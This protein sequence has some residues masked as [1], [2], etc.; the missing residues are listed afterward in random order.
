MPLVFSDGKY[1]VNL[2]INQETLD[3]LA[4]LILSELHAQGVL[5][6]NIP[7]GGNAPDIPLD[8]TKISIADIMPADPLNRFNG[9]RVGLTIKII[10]TFNQV[11]A[12]LNQQI[13]INLFNINVI[14][15]EVNVT[16]GGVEVLITR[17]PNGIGTGIGL[18]LRRVTS[19]ITTNLP[20]FLP[21]LLPLLGILPGPLPAGLASILNIVNTFI[22]VYVSLGIQSVIRLIGSVQIPI[23]QLT[24]IMAKF[25]ITFAKGS[26][27]IAPSQSIG[28]SGS[29]T[30]IVILG[31]FTRDGNSLPDNNLVTDLIPANMPGN[32]HTVAVQFDQDFCLQAVSIAYAK[33]ILD[34]PHNIAGIR[35]YVTSFTLNFKD[36][37]PSRT[38]KIVANATAKAKIRQKG[39]NFFQWIFGRKSVKVAIKTKVEVDANMEVQTTPVRSA[40]LKFDF[41]AEVKARISVVPI[42]SGILGMLLGP[43]LIVLLFLLTQLVNVVADFVLPLD[44]LKFTRN[45]VDLT[46]TLTHL[47]LG[48]DIL[49]LKARAEFHG[50]GSVNFYELLQ[51]QQIQVSAQIVQK[52][53]FFDDSVKTTAVPSGLILL[54]ASFK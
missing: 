38:A 24:D 29:R 33:G 26:P 10:L 28:S 21:S 42:Y 3:A 54:G 31:D 36:P 6:Y 34:I 48:Y 43:Q 30:G 23:S 2:Q 19:S 8:I 18:L 44:V 47:H 49:S 46:I 16:F 13:G 7:L 12:W 45:G 50:N 52:L 41:D 32:P 22:S 9:T 1:D 11:V 20:T 40:V 39:N 37:I 17:T 5:P 14:P 15:L 4:D 27:I 35:F 51:N 53:E 25:G